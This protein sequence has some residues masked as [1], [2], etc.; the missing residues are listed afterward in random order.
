MTTPS[1]V[2]LKFQMYNSLFLQL[3]FEGIEETG[4][5]LALFAQVC[6]T[7]VA[8]GKEPLQL[9]EDFLNEHRPGRSAAD[10]Y[11]LLFRFIQ[12]AEREVVLFD[13]IEDAS[14]AE[15]HDLEGKGTVKHLLGRLSDDGRRSR[16]LE[17]LQTYAVRIVL[18]AHPTQFYPGKVLGIIN[19]LGKTIQNGEV[20]PVHELLMQLGKTA[21]VNRAKPTP[22]DEALS[23]NWYLANV[24]YEAL[25][26]SIFR[27]LKGM[28]QPVHRFPN[29]R[30][31][32]LGFW[33]GGD[34]DGNPYV[35]A[36]TTLEV[37]RRLRKSI[38]SC[39]HRDIR[40]L[41]RR[42][43]FRGVEEQ[44]AAIETRIN[45]TLYYPDQPQ[46]ASCA[47]LIEDLRTA[48]KSLCNEHQSIFVDALDRFLLKVRLFGF[49][50]AAMDV[51]QESSRHE[52]V[53]QPVLQHL[54][55]KFP[56][57]F[58]YA[59]YEKM[60]EAQ[61]MTF[62]LTWKD[63]I[64]EAD[65]RDEALLETIRT[66]RAISIIQKEN[67][68][69]GCHRYIISNCSSALQVTQVLALAQ[70]CMPN[71]GLIPL[72]IV[73]LFETVEDLAG[74]H[75][76]MKTLYRQPQYAAHLKHR[77]Q[78]QTVMLGF[79][80]GTKDG[81]YLRAN[82]SIYR[83]KEALTRISREY[84][85]SI[86]FFDGRGGPPGRGGGHNAGYYAAHGSE[87]EN[88]EIQ[89]TIQ[90]QTVSSTYGTVEAATYN[91]E[92]LFTAGLEKAI[93][94]NAG[95]MPEADK[96]LMDEL[97]EA[98]YHA[99]LELKNHPDFVPYLEQVTP[100]KWYGDTNI[101]SRPTKRN[102][103]NSALVF[104]DLRAIPFVGA[105]AQMKQNVPGYFGFGKA[106]EI[107]ITAGKPDEIRQLY[108]RSRFLRALA[109]NSMQSLSKANFQLT[110]HLAQHPQFG[111]FWGMLLEEYERTKKLLMEVSG[112][113][114]LLAANPVSRESIRLREIIVLPLIVIQQFALQRINGGN[115]PE[116][117][118][119]IMRH[120]V[121]RAMFG[122]INA[123]RN[124]A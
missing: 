121:L 18:T 60:D 30:M 45:N 71:D 23:L 83:A 90:G 108:R 70:L 35:T 98:A 7:G 16:M 9:I 79:S 49:Y 15:T 26:N 99:Y 51:R 66:F 80:D 92:Q 102:G 46:Y 10:R 64:N 21:F 104:K 100:L 97:A 86:I 44:I 40:L 117:E 47:E 91:I 74:A 33:P 63:P 88:R 94:P 17:K 81:G 115:V 72:D 75:L 31:L 6:N 48:R 42:L 114:E 76:T 87:I 96:L 58:R 124:V 120:L 19:D 41:R 113:Q 22:L 84:G 24:F 107:F 85:V 4:A 12:Y 111:P 3:P 61:K 39:Y 8:E 119:E 93:H 38:L 103:D 118:M 2:A 57:L 55:E 5:L 54:E 105:W 101:A 109:E 32:A 77:G 122:I 59:D 27:L 53:L 52:T 89:V 28:K 123:G 20:E 65:Y 56:A 82:W 116:E 50:F 95:D 78:V 106:V 25:P 112:E 68:E 36:D 62:L 11:Q 73:P 67:G 43:T 37:A 29:P 34:R 1:A 13:S 69:A 14:F 110:R